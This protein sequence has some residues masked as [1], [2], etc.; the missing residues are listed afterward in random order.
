MFPFGT[1]SFSLL[2]IP[3]GPLCGRKGIMY[4]DRMLLLVHL[5]V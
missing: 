5:E 1:I 4:L 3:G 2:V